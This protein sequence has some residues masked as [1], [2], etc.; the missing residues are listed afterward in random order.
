MLLN[1]DNVPQALRCLLPLAERWGIGDDFDREHAL[2]VASSEEL[3]QLVSAIRD[4][5]TDALFEWLAGPESHNPR[6]SE[7]YL[8][9]TCL[10][11]AYESARVKL[12][13]RQGEPG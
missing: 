7:E 4:L 1:P 5:P 10:M 13:K 9:L 8:A 12:K 6:P 2:S 11:M 3:K